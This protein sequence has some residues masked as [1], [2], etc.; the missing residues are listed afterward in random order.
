MKPNTPYQFCPYCGNALSNSDIDGRP[1]PH[2]NPAGD[3]CGF[4]HFGAYTLGVGGLVVQDGRA[5]LIQRNEN[6][7]RGNWTIPGGYVEHDENVEMAVVREIEEET[8]LHCAIQGMVGLRNRMERGANST[9]VVFLLRPIGGELIS[10]PTPEIAEARFFSHDELDALAALSPFSRI[11]S[12][13]AIAG[14]LTPLTVREIPSIFAK[15]G[16]VRFFG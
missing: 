8:G 10:D 7:G 16:I 2:C 13:E 14:A 15:Q 1:R 6:P 12:Q 3:G 4:I 5:L 9:Y 11:L